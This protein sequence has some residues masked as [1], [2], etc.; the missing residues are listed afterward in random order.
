M[1]SERPDEPDRKLDA[2]EIDGE[3]FGDIMA[4]LDD[5]SDDE[6]MLLINSFEP[7]PLYD[8]LEK[9]G[10]EYETSNPGPEEWHVEITKT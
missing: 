3:P 5:L 8:V 4:A 9:R 7:E 6:S 10:F 1:R 2:R